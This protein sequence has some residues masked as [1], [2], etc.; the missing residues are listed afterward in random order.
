MYLDSISI[1]V[2]FANS[3]QNGH[4]VMSFFS[5]IKVNLS[6]A[7][8]FLDKHLILSQIEI[9]IRGF[10]FS[11]FTAQTIS[12]IFAGPFFM[13][14]FLYVRDCTKARR[15]IFISEMLLRR[16]FSKLNATAPPAKIAAPINAFRTGSE[17]GGGSA[18]IPFSSAIAG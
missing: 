6:T 3:L 13:F 14:A 7:G 2:D 10:R 15:Y 12:S 8:R 17:T 16:R 4:F 9:T 5:E 1:V 11:I 18:T